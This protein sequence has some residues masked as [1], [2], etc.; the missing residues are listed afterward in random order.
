MD[1]EAEEIGLE[2]RKAVSRLKTSAARA[3][4]SVLNPKKTVVRLK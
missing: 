1:L 2:V 4:K 3:D